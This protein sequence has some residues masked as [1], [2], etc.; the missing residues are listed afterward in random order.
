[1]MP[2]PLKNMYN[3]RFFD[4][5][6]KAVKAAYP[7][8]DQQQF[9]TLIYDDE[10]ETRE[11]KA[12]TRHIARSLHA[13]LPD[14]YPTAL[15]IMR[16]A[17]SLLTG[18]SYEPMIFPDFVE[19]YGLDDAH[20]EIS[21]DALAQFTQQTSAEFAVRQFILKD[22][23]RMMRQML[24]WAVHE[25]H[26]LRRL[27]SEGCRPRLPWAVALPA[28]KADPAPILPI[29]ELLKNDESEYVRRSVANNLND[30]SKDHPQVVLD[31]LQR[32]RERLTPEV[33][34]LIHHALRTLVKQGNPAALALIGYSGETAVRLS[35]FTVI[36]ETIS[37]GE[38]ITFSFSVESE[39]EAA[40]ELLIDYVV[41]HQRA[42][43][44]QTA[45]VFKLT[46]KTLAPAERLVIS[47]K[48]SFKPI[49]TRRYYAGEHAIEIQINGISYGKCPFTLQ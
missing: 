41:Y 36:P 43:G 31:V 5:L 47:K 11:L 29:L 40:Q 48:H 34:K 23:E 17:S 2:E 30:I 7:A 20:W 26:H 37:I 18:F 4:A 25:N 14:D 33:S 45:K 19:V 8:F 44:K 1:M 12:R 28:L 9:L 6:S 32:W 46:K 22:Q 42:G 24:A 27:A 3:T 39:R 38:E 49:T 10:W 35:G 15:A 13:L 21:M 16:E